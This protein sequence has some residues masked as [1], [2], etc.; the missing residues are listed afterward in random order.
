MWKFLD[1]FESSNLGARAKS[2]QYQMHSNGVT[3][4][5]PARA[6]CISLSSVKPGAAWPL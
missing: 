5:T 6:D 3:Y 4:V 2:M 1:W